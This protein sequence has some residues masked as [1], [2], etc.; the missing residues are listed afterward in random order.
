MAALFLSKQLLLH[1]TSLS[2]PR[3]CFILLPSLISILLSLLVMSPSLGSRRRCGAD[4]TKLRHGTSQLQLRSEPLSLD[5]G[6]AKR[7]SV[8]RALR[9]AHEDTATCGSIDRSE[10]TNPRAQV[11]LGGFTCHDTSC[12]QAIREASYLTWIIES[13]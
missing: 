13:C 2:S 7:S 1:L 5:C 4:T 9:S 3:I 12:Y 11:T 10:S 8:E 6:L